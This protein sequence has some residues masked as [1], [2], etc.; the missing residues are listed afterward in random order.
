MINKPSKPS[1]FVGQ[2][3]R[4]KKNGDKPAPSLFVFLSDSLGYI[5]DIEEVDG[6][7]FRVRIEFDGRYPGKGIAIEI[8]SEHLHCFEEVTD[9]D[10]IKEEALRIRNAPQVIWN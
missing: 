6:K 7:A 8:G 1:Y 2:R 5:A 3:L 9:Y 10:L 4:V